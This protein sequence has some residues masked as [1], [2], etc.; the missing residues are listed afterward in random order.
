MLSDQDVVELFDKLWFKL[1]RDVIDEFEAD[2]KHILRLT[3]QIGVLRVLIALVFDDQKE[4]SEFA[5]ATDPTQKTVEDQ[6]VCLAYVTEWGVCVPI[7]KIQRAI[8]KHG[9]N[10]HEVCRQM[11]LRVVKEWEASETHDIFRAAMRAH[12]ED[13]GSPEDFPVELLQVSGSSRI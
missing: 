11:L 6:L 13:E 3:M 8:R 7:D 10:P 9:R 5:L 12:W 2:G 1:T 4:I